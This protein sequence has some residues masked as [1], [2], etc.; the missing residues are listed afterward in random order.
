VAA[1]K[2]EFPEGEDP[3][4]PGLWALN[5]SFGEVAAALEREFQCQV[6]FPDQFRSLRMLL[7]LSPRSPER[8]FL[9]L[10]RR[11][12]CRLQIRFKLGK[13]ASGAPYEES[14]GM[15]AEELA[16][17]SMPREL[18]A[19]GLVAL[20]R[21]AGVIVETDPANP[22]Q[23]MVRLPKTRMPLRVTLS[24]LSRATKQAWWPVIRL[25]PRR[26]G[27][28]AAAEDARQQAYFEDFQALTPEERRE[29][30]AADLEELDR[31]PFEAEEAAL[32]RMVKDV[33][34]LGLL[35]ERNPPEQKVTLRARMR[36][37]GAD[38]WEVLSALPADRRTELRPLLDAVRAL[39]ERLREPG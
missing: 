14:D 13:P 7:K 11:L 24:F 36:L 32:A 22:P 28:G 31:V 12:N 17:A 20:L 16:P 39:R 3:T 8:L 35:F 9:P 2:V 34:G 25:T 27:S 6:E 21:R 29:E 15:F 4:Q 30:M 23:G 33:S 26:F 10:A 1:A 18:E 37:I 19:S 38:Y 5:A